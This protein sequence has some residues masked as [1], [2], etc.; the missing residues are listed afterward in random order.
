MVLLD[1]MH[2]CFNLQVARHP[3]GTPE[4]ST[5]IRGFPARQIRVH[6]GTSARLTSGGIGLNN[7]HTIA[8]RSIADP[9]HPEQ[10]AL[11]VPFTTTQTGAHGGTPAPFSHEI[12]M[13]RWP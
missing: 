11:L 4:R 3:Q 8:I 12:R 10:P 2:H 9:D 1:P 13:G 5:L 6:V 7:D